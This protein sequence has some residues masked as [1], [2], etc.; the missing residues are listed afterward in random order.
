MDRD[1]RLRK[2]CPQCNTVV[3]VKRS[4]RGCGHV[5]TLKKRKCRLVLIVY[6][7]SSE[8]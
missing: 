6:G 2:V 7:E 1:M 8:A 4:C 3:H 5:F